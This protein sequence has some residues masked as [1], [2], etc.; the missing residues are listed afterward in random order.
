MPLGVKET[1]RAAKAQAGVTWTQ[2]N[3]ETGVAQREF[4]PVG[5][6]AKSGYHRN[7]IER[8]ADYFADTEQGP[9]LRR[10]ADNDI[11]WDRVVEIT[12]VGEKQTYD[13]EVP[14]T[15]NFIANDIL[16]HNSHA[17]DYA[18]ITVQTA[19][20]KATY[21]VEYMAA[22]LLIERDKTEKVV[23]FISECRRMGIQVLPP[24]V[25]YSDLDFEIQEV[26]ADSDGGRGQEGPQHRLQLPRGR[27][28]RHPLW[29][30]RG[31]ERG[32]GTGAGDHRRPQ[33]GRPL[34]KP[35]RVL[36]PHGSAQ[37]WASGPWN[38]SSKSAPLTA[39]ASAA[40][41]SMSWR[42]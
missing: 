35:G 23:N 3:A 33:R 11:Y 4:Y 24:D 14:G 17:A 40:N 8:L 27:G 42:R 7:T 16:V 2:L 6:G 13:L 1:V 28:Q 9:D 20:L 22:L 10:Y 36:R 12:P 18:V 29:H 21:P 25:N 26:P 30:G 37:P 39:S 32:R 41:C 31:Q 19:F 15:H 5:N 38:V 34:Q